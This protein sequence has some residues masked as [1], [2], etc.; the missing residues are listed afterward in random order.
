MAPQTSNLATVIPA[1]DHIDKFLD[2]MSESHRFSLSIRAA[3]IVGKNTLNQYYTKTDQSETYWIAM[4]KSSA[5][6][7]LPFCSFLT[8]FMAVLHPRHKLAYF[9]AQGWEESWVDAACDI[10]HKEYNRSYASARPDSDSDGD[11]IAVGSVDS[12]WV[13]F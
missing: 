1:M 11:Y 10:V 3:L 8:F 2:T 4:S 7:P 13:F 6:Y 12:V 9:K 5:I